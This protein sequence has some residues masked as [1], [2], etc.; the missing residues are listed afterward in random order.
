MTD[1]LTKLTLIVAGGEYAFKRATCTYAANQSA[2]AFAFTVT[3]ATDPWGEQWNLMP[4]APCTVLANGQLIV[5]GYIER[6]LPSYDAKGHHVEISGRSKSADHL[7][8]S[9]EHPKGEFRDKTVLQIAQELDKQNVG[10]YSDVEQPKV[11][12]FR[13]NPNE[14]VFE[15]VERLSR[16][17]QLLMQGMENGSVKLTK[18]GTNGSNTPLI[19][20]HNIL[21]A[22]ACFD[23]S[24]QH[25]E[26]KVKGQ[27]VYGAD[28]RSLR[29]EATSKDSRMR[30]HRPL[31]IHQETDIDD[32]TAQKRADHH[33]NRQQGESITATI[34]TQSFF[35]D[36]GQ[37]WRANGLIYIHSPML[38][39]SNQMLL[40]TVSLNQEEHGSFSNLNFV[41]PNAFGGQGTGMGGSSGSG[42]ATQTPWM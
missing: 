41:L 15:A 1:Q 32:A 7:H 26:Y 11:E 21:A 6:M 39:L 37:L 3:D 34:K 14:K 20:G 2:R 25:S 33:K 40:K 16:R 8:S 31:H 28:R 24:D 18:G 27:R 22:S 19:E 17:Y 30:R 9:V 23:Q 35:D 42:A 5:T 29:I 38:K 13:L 36:A 12:Y 10:F 4:G